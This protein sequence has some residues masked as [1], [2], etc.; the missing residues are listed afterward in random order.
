M[1]APDLTAAAPPGLRIVEVAPSE[2]G[3]WDAYVGAHGEGT[4]FHHSAWLRTLGREYGQPV[5]GLAAQDAEGALRG[6]LPAMPTKGLPFGRPGGV[7][8]RRLASLPR[9]PV[10]GP[11]GDDASTV[12]L[13]VRAAVERTPPGAQLQIK[14][15]RDAL[16]GIDA[17]TGHPWRLSYVLDLPGSAEAVRFGNSRNHSRIRWAVNKARKEGVT[18][19]HG[20]AADLRRW[21]PLYLD[22]MRH[23]MVPPRPR[24][25][26]EL[27]WEELAPRAMARLLLAERGD[28]LLAGSIL[29]MSGSTVFYLFNGVR[30]DAFALRPND[31]LQWEAIHECAAEGYRHYDFGEVVE[32][33]EGLADFK[34]KWGTEGRR[35]HRYYHPAP[36]APPDPGDGEQSA[37]GR[38]AARAWQRV[39]LP[40]TAAV[41]DRLF[42]YL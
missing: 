13:L 6:V 22:V 32:H 27:L 37:A 20:T 15:A 16:A 39:P 30:R 23:H 17:V 33:H 21:H 35:M 41:G 9:T 12:E 2:D 31:V 28:Q 38:L 4:V 11:I 19:R 26:F 34:R 36:G 24:R 14:M 42:R 40:V 5:L 1:P 3:R 10:A 18:V 25:F 29:V 8:G 7:A